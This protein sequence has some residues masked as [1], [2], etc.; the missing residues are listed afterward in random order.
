[1]QFT[2]LKEF[3]CKETG[4]VYVPGL[5]Y[6]VLEGNAALAARVE[7]WIAAGKVR[8][9]APDSS[10]GAPGTVKGAS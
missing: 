4:S 2:P 7:K 8:L 6:H 9:G 1:M 10:G 3:T 5:S